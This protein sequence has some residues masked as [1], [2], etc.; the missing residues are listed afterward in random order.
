MSDH[1][2][3]LQWDQG[4]YEFQR[5]LGNF[6]Q[7]F[8]VNLPVNAYG[9]P[10]QII[11]P[12][13]LAENML[14]CETTDDVPEEILDQAVITLEFDHGMPLVEGLPIWER[15]DGELVPYYD[16]FK[17][18]REML[19]TGG[20]RA[21]AKLAALHNVPGKALQTISKMYH[22][23]LRCKAFDEYKKLEYARNKEFEIQ[24][25]ETAH[26]KAADFLLNEAMTY[27][28]DHPEQMNPKIA[29]QMIQVG[30]KAGRLALG[31][32]GDKPEGGH[33]SATNISIHQTSGA[34][35]GEM[36]TSVQVGNTD[37]AQDVSYLQSIVHILDQSG[38]LDKAKQNIIDADYEMISHG[39]EEDNI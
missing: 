25:L 35:T 31:L 12:L 36:T 23:Q 15:F 30:M 24:K 8:Q 18:Y 32:S 2:P 3:A 38:A 16:L 11:N 34:G 33:S 6:V 27:L 5:K 1:I 39:S 10:L 22:W 28:N 37:K 14:D 13:Y 19:Y 4:K 7:Y 26:T 17:Q 29:L 20:T 21:I 9:N